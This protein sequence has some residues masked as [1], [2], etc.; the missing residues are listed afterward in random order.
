MAVVVCY[1][2]SNTWGYDPDSRERFG[3]N[4]R[5]T[6]VLRNA[7]GSRHT[8]IEEG[9]GGRTTNIDDPVE[10]F[11]NGRSYLMPCLLSHQPFDIL[12]IMLGTND[13][14]ARLNRSA[15]DI[16]Q[17]AVALGTIAARSGAGPGGSSPR[18]LIMAPPPIV[19]PTDLDEMLAGGLAKSQDF[20][21]RF[22]WFADRAGFDFLD[23]GT[24]IKSSDL[25]GIHFEGD[26]HALLGRAVAQKI[27]AMLAEE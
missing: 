8:V 14:K 12:T 21:R 11:R 2:D 17:S 19:E 10:E 24:I 9:L 6:G 20:G 18:I 3:P 27:Q 26:Q 5:W 1:G 13:L 22:A 25:D 15:S 23:T 4:A 7:L 16:A